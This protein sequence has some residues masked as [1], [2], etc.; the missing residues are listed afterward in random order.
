[1]ASTVESGAACEQAVAIGH[2]AHILIGG[3]GR[4]Q[5]PGAAVL[6]QVNV[7]LGVKGHHPL[8]GGA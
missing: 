2:L 5:G 3:A 4:N 8:A 6:P 1:M 7:V